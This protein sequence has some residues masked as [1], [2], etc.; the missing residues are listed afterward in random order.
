[1]GVGLTR[2][3]LCARGRLEVLLQVLVVLIFGD[4]D[5]SSLA[6]AAKQLCL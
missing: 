5:H 3:F 6:R 2:C 1:M 4:M